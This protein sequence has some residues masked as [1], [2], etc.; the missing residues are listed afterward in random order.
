MD[1]VPTALSLGWRMAELYNSAEL[2]GPSTPQENA[3]LPAHLPGFGGML[4]DTV[5]LP[6]AGGPGRLTGRL[7]AL[8]RVWPG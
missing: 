1:P 7:L 2:P 5:L 6:K 4:A 8:S 3:A